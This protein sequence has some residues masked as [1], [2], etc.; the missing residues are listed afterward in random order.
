MELFEKILHSLTFGLIRIVDDFMNAFYFLAGIKDANGNFIDASNLGEDI[1]SKLFSMEISH[2]DGQTIKMT[3]IYLQFAMIA[4]GILM[5]CFIVAL[6][7][8]YIG[9]GDEELKI[10][11]MVYMKT[12]Q[13]IAWIIFVPI[14]FLLSLWVISTLISVITGIMATSMGIEDLSIGKLIIES[15]VTGDNLS[16]DWQTKINVGLSYSEFKTILNNDISNFNYWLFL[17]AGGC[18]LFGIMMATLTLVERIIHIFFY[19]LASPFVFAKLPLDQGKGFD[20]WKESVLAKFFSLA[21]IIVCA[22]LFFILQSLINRMDL[23]KQATLIKLIF[24]ISG[25]FTF[26]KAGTLVANLI[27]SSAGQ[28]EGM[29]QNASAGMLKGGMRIAG[30]LARGAGIAAM[31]AGGKGMG[32]GGNALAGGLS[33]LSGGSNGADGAFTG[34]K[35]G[36]GASS[37]MKAAGKKA[38][39]GGS[40]GV[41]EAL[42][43]GGV[44]AGAGAAMV[45]GVKGVASLA[46]KGIGAGVNA[47]RNGTGKSLA[48]EHN[49]SL[50]PTKPVKADFKN[51]AKQNA[52]A[53]LGNVNGKVGRRAASKAYKD[54]W[55]QQKS[56]YQNESSAFRNDMRNFKKMN[57]PSVIPHEPPA[58]SDDK[59]KK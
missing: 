55:K 4:F 18:S 42:T 40:S 19:Y 48:R 20:Q 10:K 41:R 44:M 54:E 13:S 47:I 2:V 51:Q 50:K 57:K 9:K 23:G 49:N 28:F 26:T 35:G 14:L 53:R 8:S 33:A 27:S 3:T 31:A 25:I 38:R 16:S 59:D 39:G 36:G 37:I 5:I 12:G 22:F 32:A 45:A 34:A 58:A 56:A 1:L 30:G 46:A 24:I 43:Y 21:G 6:L 52:A 17:L 15:C 11:N 7:K 29:S